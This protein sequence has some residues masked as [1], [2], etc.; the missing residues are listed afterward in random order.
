MT[1]PKDSNQGC[2]YWE[3]VIPGLVEHAEN[4]PT[5]PFVGQV[6]NVRHLSPGDG[7]TVLRFHHLPRAGW[8]ASIKR[9]GSILSVS[10]SDLE[11]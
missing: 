8:C 10:V 1:A 2:G 7:W 3:R 4:M 6:V 9:G 5:Y 11:V